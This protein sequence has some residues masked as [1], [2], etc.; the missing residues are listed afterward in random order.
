MNDEEKLENLFEN[1]KALAFNKLIIKAKVLSI[2]RGAVISVVVVTIMGFIILYYNAITLNK[3]GNKRD[4]ELQNFYMIAKPNSY[5]GARQFDDRFTVGELD[6]NKYRFIG[7]KAVYDG[8]YKESYGYIPLIN[9]LYGNN[10]DYLFEGQAESMQNLYE[11]QRYNKIGRRI[12]KFYLPNIIYDNYINDLSLLDDIEKDKALEI[13]L[14]FDKAY[15]IEEVKKMIPQDI[16]LNWL[17]VDTYEEE[18]IEDMRSHKEIIK[19]ET[20]EDDLTTPNI[21]ECEDNVYG[22]KALTSNGEKIEDPQN[23]F[24]NTI[25]TARLLKGTY[26]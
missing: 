23:E 3:L 24:V 25:C 7:S 1:K 6:F 16:T 2:V 22:I 4:M 15:D 11:I 26:T 9:G 20:S 18:Q 5:I 14:S 21:I 19:K 12:M 17:W 13:S 8:N 10:G